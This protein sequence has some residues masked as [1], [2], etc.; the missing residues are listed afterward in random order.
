MWWT[1]SCSSVGL[2]LLH[3]RRGELGHGDEELCSYCWDSGQGLGLL[4]GTFT[5][6]LKTA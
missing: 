2:F 5:F 1:C 3:P 4:P 6:T